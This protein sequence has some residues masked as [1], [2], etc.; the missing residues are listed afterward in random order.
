MKKLLK[1]AA[2]YTLLTVIV[3]ATVTG[4]GNGSEAA[5]KTTDTPAN[6]AGVTGLELYT[7]NCARCH[8][9]DRTGTVYGKGITAA[10]ST[11]A[12]STVDQLSTLIAF[13]RAGLHLT[14]EQLTALSN[15]LKN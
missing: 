11:I 15:Y 2:I 4:C 12:N 3:L 13:H 5:T 1:G 8:A 14:P 6:T 9:D 10:N 7:N